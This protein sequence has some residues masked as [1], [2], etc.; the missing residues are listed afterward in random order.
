MG[1]TTTG[2]AGFFLFRAFCPRKALPK[3]AHILRAKL[4][5]FS[6]LLHTPSCSHVSSY[7]YQNLCL[8][9]FPV[10]LS[11]KTPLY[12][13]PPAFS[14]ISLWMCVSLASSHEEV[15]TALGVGS[16][17]GPSAKQEAVRDVWLTRGEAPHMSQKP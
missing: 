1:F 2:T 7:L 3:I 13:P 4:S 11:L 12:H 8:H 5:L 10:L 14:V 16:G 15:V 17:L 6:P 9:P